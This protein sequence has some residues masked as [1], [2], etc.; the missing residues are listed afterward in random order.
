MSSYI[1]QYTEE[2]IR[3]LELKKKRNPKSTDLKYSFKKI[4]KSCIKTGNLAA[5]LTN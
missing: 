2:I 1:V 3:N 4:H 5:F